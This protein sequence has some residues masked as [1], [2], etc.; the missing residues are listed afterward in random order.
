MAVLLLHQGD[1]LFLGDH[2]FDLMEDKLHGI[3]L[4]GSFKQRAD[5]QHHV[6]LAIPSRHLP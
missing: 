5:K 4:L 6:A 2:H 3:Y 1:S